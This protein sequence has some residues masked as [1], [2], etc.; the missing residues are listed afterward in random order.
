[1]CAWGVAKELM[2]GD[3]LAYQLQNLLAYQLQ[4]CPV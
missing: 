2:C 1:M 4:R 3:M